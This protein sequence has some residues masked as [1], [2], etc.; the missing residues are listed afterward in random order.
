MAQI[1]HRS[2]NTLARLSIFGA[3]FVLAALLWLSDLVFRSPWF[4]GVG[5]AQ[6]Q[7]VPFSH[8]HH[9]QGVGLD[10]RYCHVHVETGAFA[11]LPDTETCMT[12][13]SQIWVDSPLLAPVRESYRTGQPLQWNRVHDLPD[14]VY[15][16]HSAHVSKG[17][18]CTTCH[19][20]V[21][22]MPLMWKSSSLQM[23]WCLDC[24]RD[25]TPNVRPRGEVFSVSWRP[26]EVTPDEQQRLSS[27]LRVESMINC[28]TC[29]R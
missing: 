13:H 28:S 6:E 1:F 4:T 5:V 2:A 7:P 23:G 18:G 24:H 19:G 14:F 3:V 26:G 17:V 25:P 8:K 12:C 27:E 29:H 10:C 9:V 20:Q 11:G 21:D 15:F 22:E 16:D